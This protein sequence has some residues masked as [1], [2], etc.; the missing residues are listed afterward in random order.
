MGAQQLFHLLS[1]ILADK[2]HQEKTDSDRE[3]TNDEK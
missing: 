2:M 1:R 3:E